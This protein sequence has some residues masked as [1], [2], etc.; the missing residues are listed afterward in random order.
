MRLLS[1]SRPAPE[2]ATSVIPAASVTSSPAAS[3]VMVTPAPPSMVSATGDLDLAAGQ[4]DDVLRPAVEGGAEDDGVRARRRVGIED[5]LPQRARAAVRG[6]R[7]RE[8]RHGSRPPPGPS[9]CPAAPLARP[10]QCAPGFVGLHGLSDLAPGRGRSTCAS[11][12]PGVRSLAG[13][14]PQRRCVTC[15]GALGCRRAQGILRGSESVSVLGRC[16]ASAPSAA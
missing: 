8:C 10:F 16:W 3:P 5:R 9:P 7:D 11:L 2:A 6:V 14:A 13:L 15:C 1:S 4:P 12:P